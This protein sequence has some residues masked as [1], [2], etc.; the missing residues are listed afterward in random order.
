MRPDQGRASGR[1]AGSREPSPHGGSR[2]AVRRPA[3]LLPPA[4]GGSGSARAAWRE[5]PWLRWRRRCGRPCSRSPR[6]RP[7]IS[8]SVTGT[9]SALTRSE[10]GEAAWG[11]GRRGGPCEGGDGAVAFVG[12]AGRSPPALSGR[13]RPAR[14]RA[15]SSALGSFALLRARTRPL[16]VASVP[17]RGPG[18]FGPADPPQ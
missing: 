11:R 17:P 6:C 8:E 12:T 15:Q 13:G 10:R 3:S 7:R 16:A 9:G 14:D 1:A 5:A 4:E 2:L 18:A